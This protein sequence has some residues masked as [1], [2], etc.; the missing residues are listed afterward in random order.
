MITNFPVS[1]IVLCLVREKGTS[2]GSNSCVESFKG[3]EGVILPQIKSKLY[4]FK[5][6]CVRL[7]KTEPYGGFKYSV[8]NVLNVL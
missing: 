1:T 2:S 8:S 4:I 3:R 5:I 6:R 7:F